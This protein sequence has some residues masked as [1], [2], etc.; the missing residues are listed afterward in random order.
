MSVTY[1]KEYIFP[2]SKLRE[3][4][5][6]LESTFINWP[7]DMAFRL[8]DSELVGEAEDEEDVYNLGAGERCWVGQYVL[9]CG[10]DDSIRETATYFDYPGLDNARLT[11]EDEE[12]E[13]DYDEDEGYS[14]E[15][16]DDEDDIDDEDDFESA[17]FQYGMSQA[18][19][20]YED[21]EDEEDEVEDEQQL[22]RS[23]VEIP[24]E[25]A[26][27]VDST[28]SRLELQSAH[29]SLINIMGDSESLLAVT[30]Y[31]TQDTAEYFT[32]NSNGEL[33][34]RVKGQ[35]VA[36]PWSVGTDEDGNESVDR[37]VEHIRSLENS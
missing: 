1:S 26:L 18:R 37:I 8:P 20:S 14:A 6:S 28:W 27:Q 34:A 7:T 5:E 21:E 23:L 31:I 29:S 12:E 3:V 22:D 24:F 15:E 32:V 16:E 35:W 30:E 11:D 33:S 13:D 9:R 10:I 4:L 36:L 19:D 25:V 17:A 2:T